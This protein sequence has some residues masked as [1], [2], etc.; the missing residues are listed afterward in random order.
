MSLLPPEQFAAGQKANLDTLFGLTRTAFEGWQRL[1]EL[2]LQAARST[3]AEEQDSVLL[4]LSVRD[5]QELAM[6]PA[7]M[8]QPTAGKMQSYSR[9]V[10]AIVTAMQTGFAK[11]AEAQ[12]EAH[13]RRVQMLVDTVAQSAPAG[14]EAAVAALKSAVTATGTLYE[15]VQRTTRQA[16]EV[17][18]SNFNIAAAEAS[19]ATQHALRQAWRAAK[20]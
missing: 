1:V 19:K 11:V 7:R 16:V 4:A 3:L 17:T 20:E 12:Y 14:S 6:L 10:F 9:E 8:M 13:N 15:T 5:P 18:E 2:N